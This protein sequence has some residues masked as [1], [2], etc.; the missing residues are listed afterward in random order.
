MLPGVDRFSELLAEAGV[1]EA[2]TLVAYD[3]EHGVFAARFVVTA[4][5]YGHDDVHLLDGDYSAWSRERETTTEAPDV[6][7]TDYRAAVPEDRPLIDAEAVADAVDDPDAVLVDTRT[8]EEFGAGHIDGAIQLDWRE[9]VDPDT[10]GLKP[11]EV[12][13]DLLG[14]ATRSSS[15]GTSASPGWTS[16]RGASPTGRRGGWNSSR[17]S[18]NPGDRQN[19]T[20]R[21]P[22]HRRRRRARGPVPGRPPGRGAR[23]TPRGGRR[24]TARR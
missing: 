9:L 12:L 21:A 11:R 20:A 15:S 4:L 23:R 10:R 18:R 5:F 7:P 14:S 1:D 19:L 24:P 17:G 6:E 2:D 13:L 3:D 8:R 22:P 16:T